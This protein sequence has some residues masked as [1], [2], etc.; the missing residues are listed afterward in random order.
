MYRLYNYLSENV[1]R[2]VYSGVA[3]KLT[4]TKQVFNKC[5]VKVWDLF[6]QN[7]NPS[8]K[9]IPLFKKSRLN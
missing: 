9:L 8:R 1:V 3:T 6:V 2:L 5:L 7:K 4:P